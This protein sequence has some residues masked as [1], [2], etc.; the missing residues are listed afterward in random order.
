M[1]MDKVNVSV[2]RSTLDAVP[3]RALAFLRGMG[4][5]VGI[6]RALFARGY[7]KDD[8]VEGWKLLHE[9]SGFGDAGEEVE[10]ATVREAA[11]EIDAWD[12]GAIRIIQATFERRFPEQAAFVLQGIRPATGAA[13]ILGVAR[14]LERLDALEESDER[15]DSRKQDRAAL[16]LLAR[17]GIDAKERARVRSLVEQAKQVGEISPPDP[18]DLEAVERKRTESL[19]RLY[20]WHREW[21]EIARVTIRRRDQ[22]IRLGLAYRKAAP[23]ED[24]ADD[25][26]AGNALPP[27]AAES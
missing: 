14:L 2:S 5:S 6:R 8:H 15:K 16:E 3:E 23:G 18:E 21:S 9:V 19:M 4:L 7:T 26:P 25:V 20:A 13:A 1:A 27:L 10:D 17:R 22:L 24:D 11:L 12:E